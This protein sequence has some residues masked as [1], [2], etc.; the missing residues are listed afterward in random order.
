MRTKEE[1]LKQIQFYRREVRR[2]EDGAI[3]LYRNGMH[4]DALVCNTQAEGYRNQINLCKW[5]LNETQENKTQ[6]DNS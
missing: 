2:C 3:L 5:F 6:E 4:A 1:V